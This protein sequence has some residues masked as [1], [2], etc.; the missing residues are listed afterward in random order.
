MSYKQQIHRYAAWKPQMHHFH[1]YAG[2]DGFYLEKFLID[3]TVNGMGWG[4]PFLAVKEDAPR[5]VGKPMVLTPWMDHPLIGDE[6]PYDIGTIQAVNVSAETGAARQVSEITDGEAQDAIREGRVNYGSVGGTTPR[7]RTYLLKLGYGQRIPPKDKTPSDMYVTDADIRAIRSHSWEDPYANSTT[8]IPIAQIG[9][10]LNPYHDALVSEPAY[11]R[12]KDY[13][14]DTCKGSKGTCHRHLEDARTAM[15][16]EAAYNLPQGIATAASSAL[17]THFSECQV[18]RIASLPGE[19]LPDSYDKAARA[20]AADA[21]FQDRFNSLVVD[22][23]V[24]R[25][26]GNKT[27]H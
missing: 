27:G 12:Q 20:I 7:D 22:Y 15:R 4:I 2:H 26:I 9:E 3:D 17:R 14:A 23:A 13:I 11:G 5:F 19:E 21:N 25:I 1:R 24:S 6:R 8:G 16:R 18:S 10:V